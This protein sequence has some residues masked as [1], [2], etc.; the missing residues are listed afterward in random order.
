MSSTYTADLVSLAD[1][2]AS[3][4]LGCEDCGNATGSKP[5]TGG[6]LMF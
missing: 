2:D 5:G 4:E 6:R 3:V 1:E